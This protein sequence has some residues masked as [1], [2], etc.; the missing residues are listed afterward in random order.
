MPNDSYTQQ[1]LAMEVSFRKRVRSAMSSVAWTVTAEDPA[2]PNHFNRN[3]YANMVIRNLDNEVNVVMPN[4]VFRPNVMNFATTYE[5]DFQNQ[6]G[7]VVSASGDADLLSQIASDW[8]ELAS[9]AGFSSAVA[10]A[11]AIVNQ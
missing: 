6:V 5:Y 3:N 4:I 9:A 7:A 10:A 11:T 1:A 2:T 8:N